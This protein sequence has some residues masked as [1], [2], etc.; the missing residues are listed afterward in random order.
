MYQITFAVVNTTVPTLCLATSY[1]AATKNLKY[2]ELHGPLLLGS[3]T[4]ISFIFD[5]IQLSG[6]D[7]FSFI[8]TQAISSLF[9]FIIYIGFLT[10]QFQRHF[11]IRGIL[12]VMYRSLI[13]YLRV[14]FEEAELFAIVA[15]NI[16]LWL[17]GE[18]VFHVQM[19]AQVKLFLAGKVTAMQQQQ[20]FN[21]LDSVPDSVLICSQ[22][23]ESHTPKTLYSNRRMN[24]FFDR[25]IVRTKEKGKKRSEKKNLLNKPCF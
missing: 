12:F 24:Q 2:V 17:C 7:D 10:P 23:S 8:Q 18:I 19:K 1:F 14:V 16:L 15:S 21:L 20:L 25:E 11:I 3:S 5:V 9:Y 6:K 4:A 13:I 22:Q